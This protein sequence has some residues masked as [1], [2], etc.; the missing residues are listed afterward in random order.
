MSWKSY[1]FSY[2]RVCKLQEALDNCSKDL[3][4]D[5]L[6]KLKENAEEISDCFFL[7][8]QTR[9]ENAGQQYPEP[10]RKF[11]LSLH[12]KSATAY[13]YVR[14]KFKVKITSFLAYFLFGKG[15]NIFII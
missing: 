2:F 5:S 9:E 13:R 4:P 7:K 12:L 14:A 3:T 8:Y 1:I 6:L 10:L 11:A 15:E